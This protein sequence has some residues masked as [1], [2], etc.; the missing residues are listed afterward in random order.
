MMK[1]ILSLVLC[2]SM[3]VGSFGLTVFAHGIEAAIG[4]TEYATFEEAVASA[5][6]GDVIILKDNVTVEATVNIT[7][8]L[9]LRSDEGYAVIGAA[10]LEESVFNITGS[11]TLMG[12][13]VWDEPM[14]PAHVITV[15]GGSFT[16][17]DGSSVNGGV[18]VLGGVFNF[19]G[20]ILV[21][22]SNVSV[23]ASSTFRMSGGASFGDTVYINMDPLTYIEIT[24]DLT[25]TGSADIR[26]GRVTSG[27][28]VAAL[29]AGVSLNAEQLSRFKI[30]GNN[31]EY[32][33]ML[34]GNDVIVD[35]EVGNNDVARIGEVGYP[36]LKEAFQ[37]A[38]NTASATITLTSVAVVDSP[39]TV[40]GNITLESDGNYTVYAGSSLAGSAFVIDK[41]SALTVSDEDNSVT[42]SGTGNG[43]ALFD[44]K[45]SLNIGTHTLVTGNKN[46]TEKYNKG[47][48][49]VN[50]GTLT[51]TGVIKENTSKSGTV[52]IDGGSFN[53]TG[54]AICNN[55]ATTAGGVYV[56]SGSFNMG[57][58]ALIY[59]NS[60]DGVWTAGSFK[61]SGRA[62]VY[63]SATYPA[64]IFLSNSSVIKLASDWSPSVAPE[65]YTS[66]MPIAMTEPKLYDVVAE[67]EGTATKDNFKMSER[68]EN[69]FALTVKDKKLIVA[70]ADEVYTVYWG[71][72]PYMTLEEAVA[73]L[74]ANV[75]ATL[76]VVGDT[77]VSAP[78]VIKQGMNITVTTDTNPATL[79]DYTGR[80]VK[81]AQ[82][83]TDSI[84]RVEK[85]ATLILEAAEGKTLT[86]DGESKKVTSAMIVTAGGVAVGK[87]VS[88][89]A[90]NNKSAEKLTGATPVFTFGGGVYVEKGGSCT[91][92]GGSIA[93]NYASYGAGVY[94]NDGALALT[95]GEIKAN[96]A[97]YGAGVYLETTGGDKDIFAT[98]AM[99]GGN[100][101]ENKAPAVSQ[102][103]GSGVAGG[104]Y[105]TNG[106]SFMM[107]GGSLSKNTAAMAAGVCVG[108]L[109]YAAEIP[110][111]KLVLS[112]K[113]SIASDNSVY[114]AI[115][116][117][118]Y[119]SVSSNLTAG[120]S[121]TI[122]LPATMPQN[123]K[124]VAFEYGDNK[125]VNETAAQ[126]A[127]SAKK[128]VLDKAASEYF[129][130]S[131]SHA[132][133]SVLVNVAG[134]YLPSRTKAGKHHNG[135]EM[136]VEGD[137]EPKEGET[138]TPVIYDPTVIRENGSFTTY[139]EMS[140]YPN[141]Y[142]NINS[143]ITAPFLEGTRIVMIDTTD[144]KNIGYYYYE[145][146]DKETVVE[147]SEAADGKKT[148]DII[149]IPLVNF[150]KMG[151]K[152]TF[153][154]PKVNEDT[155]KKAVTK[156]KLLF[157]VDFTDI[158][159][160]EGVTCEGDFRMVWNHYYPG[161][162]EGER[163]DI[164]GNVMVSEYKVASI[165]ASTV[166]LT[167]GEDNS[168]TVSYKLANDSTALAENK[169]V[170]LFQA[171][172]SFPRGTVFSDAEGRQ[173]VC[174]GK[175][176]AIAVPV[177]TDKDGNVVKEGSVTYTLSN[178]YGTAL[179]NSTM[180]CVIAASDDGLHCSVGAPYDAESEG[181]K[182]DLKADDEYSILV[183]TPDGTKK[184]YYESYDVLKES[185]SL[186]MTVKGLANTTEVD[187]FNLSLLKKVGGE[188]VTCNLSELFKVDEAYG[189]EV[190]LNT[191]NLSLELAPGINELM[192]NEYKIVFKVGD[193]VEYVKVNVIETKK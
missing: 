101:T 39:I 117:I 86:F 78:V 79:A 183:T 9:T 36:T 100:V 45:G 82:S 102:I 10:E 124:L 173:Y 42:V 190:I 81:R 178:Y 187:S 41:G 66:A 75:Q 76:K 147:E 5:R 151:T 134:D 68:Y 96:T 126:K 130:V 107:S 62:A 168:F 128:F 185:A 176:A 80:T 60:G 113:A 6:N 155:A 58:T 137:G 170:I 138:K 16:M 157:V 129:A 119:V 48:I 17:R 180:R 104:V 184:P 146:G 85:G 51:S 2:L 116:D 40:K 125:T 132:D 131:L 140:Y 8:T 109:K 87:G 99:A 30:Y 122:S 112:D 77:V 88:I 70:A 152:D 64:T 172:D 59:A 110:Q 98:F 34:N 83:F 165:S 108:V 154:A 188:Y 54:G 32:T 166:S 193:A 7:K 50:G 192:G 23:D 12:V 25:G 24:G 150:Y 13:S 67:F 37:A 73:D 90:N 43:A 111:P 57:G 105:I 21:G 31:T 44:V 63:S 94:A 156:E 161:E 69:K 160:P 135:L 20:G 186:E 149:E 15:S 71:N 35:K 174:A 93:G 56:A 162:T 159:I 95:E 191:G 61:L 74:P 11:L 47:A 142:K 115:P 141:L 3:L 136:Y 72:N 123:M 91:I 118:S 169:G 97:L 38:A 18:N 29:S 148:P 106:S 49:Y 167:A 53:M 1:R 127:L 175:A 46:T 27:D 153:Y 189:N 133:K 181:I 92:N 33:V 89:K 182:V 158:R 114:L 26:Y 28:R 52:Y 144:E 65:G 145:V 164:S 179:V 177:P 103:K 84:F 120:G 4:S 139:Y 171:G 121:V 14:C 163:Y 19:Y 143:Y 22:G 55:T